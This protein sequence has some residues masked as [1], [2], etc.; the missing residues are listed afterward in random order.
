MCPA[1]AGG[2]DV[3]WP[4]T[5]ARTRKVRNL[6]F[7]NNSESAA[8]LRP[9]SSPPSSTNQRYLHIRLYRYRTESSSA[10]Y[11]EKTTRN[12]LASLR[13]VSTGMIVT[14]F[15]TMEELERTSTLTRLA[16]LSC[17][18]KN[19]GTCGGSF[20][21][22]SRSFSFWMSLVVADGFGGSPL[23]A[24]T[25]QK[26]IMNSGQLYKKKRSTRTFIIHNLPN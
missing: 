1:S 23:P 19:H 26:N 20:N 21:C 14:E 8:P 4:D 7:M 16:L 9:R 11:T 10:G 17:S 6:G 2:S 3:G 13:K 12:R 22:A 5:T 25:D 24:D 15:D 18:F